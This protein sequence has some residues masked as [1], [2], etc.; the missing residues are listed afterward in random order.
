MEPTI[1][2]SVRSKKQ[3]SARG[4]TV[5]TR[6]VSQVHDDV[7]WCLPPVLIAKWHVSSNRYHFLPLGLR[8]ER[9]YAARQRTGPSVFGLR[10][11]GGLRPDS[12]QHVQLL[13]SI[14]GTSIT[15]LHKYFI[16]VPQCVC[17]CVCICLWVSLVYKVWKNGL[18]NA[19]LHGKTLRH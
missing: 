9:C 8:S 19:A 1:D 4:S 6:N 10:S 11:P 14:D 2:S 3:M 18:K 12:S 5:G 15:Y 7:W 13:E 17:V 16:A